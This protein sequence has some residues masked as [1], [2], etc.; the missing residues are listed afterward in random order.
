MNQTENGSENFDQ[1]YARLIVVLDSMDKEILNEALVYAPGKAP[2]IDT[3]QF[4]VTHS[5]SLILR[6]LALLLN[7]SARFSEL[8]QPPWW[9]NGDL[10]WSFTCFN[11]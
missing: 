3:I 5:I 4:L 9:A 7:R 11:D 10:V 6:G 1:N 2:N 8:G